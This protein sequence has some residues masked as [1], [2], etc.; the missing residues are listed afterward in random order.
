MK[1]TDFAGGMQVCHA[2]GACIRAAAILARGHGDAER[3]STE[4][5]G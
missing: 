4:R 3:D 5:R 2:R 1:T